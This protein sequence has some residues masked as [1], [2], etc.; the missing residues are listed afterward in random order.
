VRLKTAA[1]VSGGKTNPSWKDV[2]FC[3]PLDYADTIGEQ[4]ELADYLRLV[5]AMKVVNSTRTRSVARCASSAACDWL[6]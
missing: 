4:A 2:E 3:S 5:P 1:S 6:N